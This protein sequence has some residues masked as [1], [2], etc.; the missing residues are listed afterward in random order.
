MSDERGSSLFTHR[1]SL[2][3][4]GDPVGREWEVR[5]DIGLGGPLHQVRLADAVEAAAV[6]GEQ[7][8]KELA[9]AGIRLLGSAAGAVA[10]FDEAAARGVPHGDASRERF[11]L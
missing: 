6:G 2:P 8:D 5:I 1:S 9:V 3:S 10:R 4:G 7:A 11:R